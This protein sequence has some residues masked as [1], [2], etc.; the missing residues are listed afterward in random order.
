MHHTFSFFFTSLGIDHSCIKLQCNQ[1]VNMWDSFLFLT[2]QSHAQMKSW[3]SVFKQASDFCVSHNRPVHSRSKDR[4][5]RTTFLWKASGAMCSLFWL[6][7]KEWKGGYCISI[8]VAFWVRVQR[9]KVTPVQ[10]LR[11]QVPSKV[12]S[13]SA[14][15]RMML[16][17]LTKI[18][19]WA[20][21]VVHSHNNNKRSNINF[22]W[23]ALW[24]G[25]W[26]DF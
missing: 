19:S 24:P 26:S 12:L 11:G 21:L 8:Y 9:W 6:G 10:R 5:Y 13:Q 14:K 25:L 20:A 2:V 1:S 3:Q 18:M 4:V 22:L 15:L 17:A 16:T 7:G 23:I